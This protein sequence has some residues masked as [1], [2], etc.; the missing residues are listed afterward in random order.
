MNL[1]SGIFSKL[2]VFYPQSFDMRILQ[3]SGSGATLSLRSK[4]HVKCGSLP[5]NFSIAFPAWTIVGDENRQLN[6]RF[7]IKREVRGYVLRKTE[8]CQKTDRSIE[9]AYRIPYQDVMEKLVNLD[10]LLGFDS[11]CILSD[12]THVAVDGA[13]SNVDLQAVLRV[14][15]AC[16]LA[17]D[18]G[19]A[20]RGSL[21][22]VGEF[23]YSFFFYLHN[24]SQDIEELCK[25]SA[26]SLEP[27]CS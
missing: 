7:Q 21:S 22:R 2:H 13:E 4:F 24:G 14:F 25:G 11:P 26:S 27:V 12:A 18:P 10:G 23:I 20:D 19:N 15:R 1:S 6:A 5:I 9:V 3:S 8:S 17:H 16:G